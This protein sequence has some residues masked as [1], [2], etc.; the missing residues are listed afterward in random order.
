MS[1]SQEMETFNMKLPVALRRRLIALAK[2]NE[3]TAAAEARI[4]VREH[5]DRQSSSAT[6]ATK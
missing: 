1:D 5:L 4:A 3:R 2:Q 6:E